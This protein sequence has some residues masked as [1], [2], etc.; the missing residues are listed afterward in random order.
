MDLFIFKHPLSIHEQSGSSFHHSHHHV[1][2]LW[3]EF[4]CHLE[5]FLWQAKRFVAHKELNYSNFILK[6]S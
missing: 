1:L 3:Q 6:K 2:W 5:L 4:L